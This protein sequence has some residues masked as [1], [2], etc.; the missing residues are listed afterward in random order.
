[1]MKTMTVKIHP[2]TDDI[3]LAWNNNGS[4]LGTYS[5]D[6]FTFTT[7]DEG[8]LFAT[9]ID[10]KALLTK[11]SGYESDASGD[12]DGSEK[13]TYTIEGIPEGTVVTLGGQSTTANASGIATIVFNDTNNKSAD[14]SFTLKFPEYW[15]GDVTNAKI[16]L[17]VQDRG[18]D[19][20]DTPGAVKT[21]EV[22]FNVTVNPIANLATLQIKQ[23]IGN[24]DAGRST[25]NTANNSSAIDQPQNGILLDIKVSSD[26]KDGSE[27][28]NVRIDDIPNG[29]TLYVYDNSSSTW[30][31]VDNTDVGTDGNLTI[32]DNGDG[33]WK[34]VIEDFQNNQ[35]P[36]F[37][38]P[39]NSDEDYTF[40]INA[41]TVDG[42]DTWNDTWLTLTD[43]DMQVTVKDI[44]DVPVG[45]EL[46]EISQNGDTYALV[47]DENTDLDNGTPANKFDLKD[48]YI[49]ST[50]LDSYDSGSETLSIVISNLSSGF[51]VEGA[52]LIGNGVWTFLADNINSIKITT[53]A[54]FS[55]EAT[56][57]LKYVTTEDAGD[58]KTHHT[59]TVKIF[60][61]PTAEATI[62]TA[63]TV[64][65]DVLTKVDF[66]I[67]HQNGDTN[68]TLEEIRIKV[69]DVE[70]KDFTLY[71]GNST[72]T[73]IS[74]L[75]PVGGYYILTA[76]QANNVYALNTTQH[77]H[78]SYTFEVGYTVRDTESDKNTYD[79]ITGTIN[80]GLTINAVTDTPT[81]TIETISSGVGYS[82]TGTTVNVSQEDITFTIPV[83]VTSPDM[84]GS[85]DVTQFVITGVPMGVEVVGG[86]YYGYAGSIHN[87]IWVLD[88]ADTAITDANGYTENIQFKVNPGADF[89]TRNITI[90]AFNQDDGASTESDTVSFTL[91]KTYTAS[92][93]V[94]TPPEFSLTAKEVTILEDVAF[95]LGSALGVT[96]TGG[97][98]TG[99]FAVTITD[100]PDGSSVSGHSYSYVENGVTRYVITGTGAMQQ[101][102]KL[103]Y[104]L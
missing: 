19:G 83:K 5:G 41:Q 61:S 32:T 42:V 20:G 77:E 44:A 96:K 97:G 21:D 92:G 85:E 2:V 72:D 1:M 34:I 99:G 100:L 37:I 18:V 4:G 90:E 64:S 73:P 70:G 16:T 80:Y 60:V 68:E 86:T 79:E 26:D 48:I 38:P 45:T 71:L 78:G 93:G 55:G 31:L 33:T 43:K 57:N 27:T 62:S 101:M 39:H 22:Y 103:H 104:Q 29:G 23:A 14:P 49:N 25:G 17:S 84:D 3:S 88:I 67:A 28:F 94:G 69:D 10:L 53:P 15:S 6:V 95:N 13:R 35:L 12:L 91:E 74:T 89:E 11:T 56:F 54:N 8:Y 82:A 30:K 7:V 76:L 87:G 36:R 50:L 102:L 65:E 81:A 9:P 98:L 58:S 51:G 63:T 47:L 52:S 75:T 46:N 24:E 66:S 40:K 59:D